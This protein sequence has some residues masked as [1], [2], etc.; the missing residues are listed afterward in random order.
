MKQLKEK[1]P[2]CFF[3]VQI[4]RKL[5]LFRKVKDE[6]YIKLSS[7]TDNNERVTKKE[8]DGWREIRES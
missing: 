5:S 3:S 1:I 8:E 4:K 6:T 2:S 7:F